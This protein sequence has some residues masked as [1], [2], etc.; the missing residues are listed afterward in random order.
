MY[1]LLTLFLLVLTTTAWAK[2]SF[3]IPEKT[4][5]VVVVVNPGW[6]ETSA[7]MTCYERDSADAPWRKVG[8]NVPVNLGRTGLAWGRSPVMKQ[9]PKKGDF[10]SKKEGDGR[11]PAGLFPITGAFGH[12][13][14]PAG[15]DESNLPFTTLDEQQCVDDGKS[16]YYNQIVDPKEVGGRTWSSAEKMKIEVYQRGL[17]VAH[18]CPKAEPGAGSCIF[19]HL[20]SG[21]GET[22]SGCT[23]MAREPMERLMLWLKQES[24][25]LVLQLP[26]QEMKALPGEG[27]PQK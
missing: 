19:F 15:Y 27:W 21:P 7:T 14:A 10:A 20:Q 26:R 4:L 22:T 6:N 3:Q 23:S 11:S 18:N 5:Q 12:P 9:N 17:V 13:T 8:K 2:P 16:P 25:P 24:H 1:K